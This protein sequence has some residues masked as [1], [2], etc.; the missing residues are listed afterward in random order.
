MNNNEKSLLQKIK[1]SDRNAFQ[2]IFTKYHPILFRYIYYRIKNY[3][4]AQDIVQET[5]LKVWLNR[6]SLKP[7]LAFFPYIVKISSNLVKDHYKHE[8]VRSKYKNSIPIIENS[9]NDD[10]DAALDFNLLEQQINTTV[11]NNLPE[12]CRT[13]FILSRVEGKS[14]QEIADLLNISKKTVENQLYHALKVLRTKL[15]DFFS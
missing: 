5:F 6:E 10:P 12:K 14:N 13:I 1:Q 15:A 11:N 7:R 8:Q 2:Q 9:M 4:L 3:S